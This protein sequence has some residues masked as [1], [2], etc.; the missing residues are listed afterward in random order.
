MPETDFGGALGGSGLGGGLG[1]VN[2]NFDNGI[3]NHGGSTVLGLFGS[4]N[5]EPAGADV[6]RSEVSAAATGIGFTTRAS[7]AQVCPWPKAKWV[8]S[9]EAPVNGVKSGSA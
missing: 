2:T 7:T 1:A 4:L 5:I 6:Y 9:S 8:R 3:G